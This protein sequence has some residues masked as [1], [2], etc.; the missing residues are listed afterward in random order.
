MGDKSSRP[1]IT[2]HVLDTSLGRPA[3]G[4]DIQLKLLSH[5]DS[6]PTEPW[7]FGGQTNKDGR[8]EQ[9]KVLSGDSSVLAAFSQC[10]G[11]MQCQLSFPTTEYWKHKSV[12][13]F[14]NEVVISFLTIGFKDLEKSEPHP[15]W[16]VPVLMGPFNYTTYRGS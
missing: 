5:N 10:S 9:W 12:D 7:T 15:H 4:L 6:D 14:F 11:K 8:V 16:H 3:E 2:C 1:P 13:P